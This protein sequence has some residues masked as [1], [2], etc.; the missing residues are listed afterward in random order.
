MANPTEA[1]Q[2]NCFMRTD[3]T[4]KHSMST[5]MTKYNNFN[6]DH[7]QENHKKVTSNKQNL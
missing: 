5:Q 6:T 7:N 1:L 3:K 4:P 2:Q